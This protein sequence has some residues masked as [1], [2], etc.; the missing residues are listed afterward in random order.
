MEQLKSPF[1]VMIFG[2]FLLTAPLS[3]GG[4]FVPAGSKSF[5]FEVHHCC[6]FTH[7]LVT[8]FTFISLILIGEQLLHHKML[9]H[10]L[11]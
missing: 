6:T 8:R 10:A 11:N 4:L 2:E 5:S 3:W 9:Y 7:S 1:A